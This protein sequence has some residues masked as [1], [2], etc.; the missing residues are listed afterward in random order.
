MK[1]LCFISHT[2]LL[3]SLFQIFWFIRYKRFFLTT[4]KYLRGQKL[5]KI[6]YCRLNPFELNA[7]L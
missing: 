5:K 1:Y 3:I 7:A 4:C 2:M 6:L